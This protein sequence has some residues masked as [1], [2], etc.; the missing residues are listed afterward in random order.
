MLGTLEFTT[1]EAAFVLRE[2]VKA[3]RKALDDGPVRARLVPKAGGSVRAIEWLDL[4]YLHAVRAL[5]DELTPKG[6][7]EFYEALK[8]HPSQGSGEVRFGLLSVAIDDFEAEVD[9]RTRELSA[10]AEAIE[11]GPSGEVFL[12][13][14]SIEAHRI[15]ALREGGL[16]FQDIVADYPSLSLQAVA[17][18]EAYAEVYPKAGPPYPR[19]TVK[20]ALQGAGLEALDGVWDEEAAGHIELEA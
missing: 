20:R 15:A 9:A 6:R 1:A 8:L 2:P 12:K 16:S 4:V 17:V 5:R 10:L 3:V 14:T 11:F 19:T 13:G 7:A 18:A